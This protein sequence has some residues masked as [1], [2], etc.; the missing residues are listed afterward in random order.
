MVYGRATSS[1]FVFDDMFCITANPSIVNLWPP[2]GDAEQ[3]GPLNPAKE[4]STAGRPL[5]NLSLALNYHFGG[6]DPVGY[7]VFN[8]IVHVLSALLLMAIVRRTLCLHYFEGRFDHA[9]GPLS[10]LAALLWAVHPLQTETVIYVTQRTELMVGFFYLATL[11]SSLRY[12]S[13]LSPAARTT[14]LA[15]STLACLAGMA[16]KEVMVTAPLV[17]LLFERTFLAGS[18]RQAIR[19]SW[20]LYAGLALGWV[21]L[22]G[23]NYNGP[24]SNSAGFDHNVPAYAWWLTQ[25]KVLWMYLKLAVWPWP[26]TIHYKLPY[27]TSPASAWPWLLP[28]ALLI[29]ATLVLWW[30]RNPIGF[31]GAWVLIILSPTLVVPI[32]TEVAAERRMYLP[33]AALAALIVAGGYRLAQRTQ[34]RPVSAE[35][36]GR[37][38]RSAGKIAAAA[39]LALVIL[40][41]L[42][43]VR[44][45]AAYH[46]SVTLWQDAAAYQPDDPVVRN[47]LGLEL[48][49]AGRL[50]EAMEQYQ[51]AL[52]LNPDSIEAYYNLGIALANGGHTQEAIANFQQALQRKPNGPSIHNNLGLALY[53]AGQIQ[54]AVDHYQEALRLKPD[55]PEA[56]NNLGVALLNAGQTQESIKRFRHALR[57]QPDYAE[58]HVNLGLALYNSG[59]SQ[60]AIEHYQQGLRLKPDYPEA[61]NNLA[62]ALVHAGRMQEAIEHLEQALRLKPDYAQAHINLGVVLAKTGRPQDAIDHYQEAVRLKP[63][64]ADAWANLAKAYAQIHRSSDAT[65]AAQKA[66]ELARSQD[67]SALAERIE[68]WL[69]NY[70]SQQAKEPDAPIQSD[71]A[72][73]TP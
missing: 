19:K 49:N 51:Q 64:Y 8:L 26:L 55:Y 11:Y 7:H 50:Q 73:P 69:T 32:V 42:V 61:H 17:V 12:W 35:G 30:R 21:L 9:S 67:Q 54:Q 53:E 48:A 72:R 47:N 37:A 6:L 41:S 27:L 39:A 63:D 22:L 16:S 2:I 31:V 57:I 52:R 43:S 44:R 1:P 65:T 36:S 66:L 14:W 24:R 13:A 18:F 71:N 15:L 59:Q 62:M 58:A 34:R 10:L 45:L 70:R 38:D 46:N 25:T 68:G 28:T 4:L 33:L 20:P 23:L 56:Y 5:V 29:L 40:L 60:E 3:P